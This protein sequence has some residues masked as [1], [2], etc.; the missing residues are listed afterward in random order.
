M[1]W[2]NIASSRF[3]VD[4]PVTQDLF[5]DII[6]NF[7]GMGDGDAGAPRIT[8]NAM[9]YGVS[10]G[11]FIAANVKGS[12][13]PGVPSSYTKMAE[14]TVVIGGT[15]R[16]R[17]SIDFTGSGANDPR[18]RIYKNGVAFGVERNGGSTPLH[19]D[20]DL[21]FSAGDTFEV[22]GKDSTSANETLSASVSLCT[23]LG[24]AESSA[25]VFNLSAADKTSEDYS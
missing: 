11:D 13:G 24:A 12:L 20:E 17:L 14:L 10:A 4:A 1:A 15:Y 3:S 7:Q 16:T 18:C 2:I 9:T 6:G 5:A 19:Y 25:S 8:P 22:W 21:A 23:T